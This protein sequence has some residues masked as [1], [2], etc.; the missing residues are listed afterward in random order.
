MLVST[1]KFLK[2][3]F[4][5]LYFF[6]KYLR[7][8]IF[9]ALLLNILVG[10][11]DGIGLTMF[12]PLLNLLEN[13]DKNPELGSDKIIDFIHKTGIDLNITNI[14]ILLMLVFLFK[15]TFKLL[16]SIFELNLHIKFIRS[17]RIELFKSFFNL[18][19]KYFVTQDVGHIQ[20]TFTGE[21]SKVSSACKSY[22]TTLNKSIIVATYIVLALFANYQFTFI[23]I[24]VGALSS[25]FYGNINKKT[26]NL[27]FVLVGRN[28]FFQKLIIEQIQNFKY[29][30]VSGRKNIF[31]KKVNTGIIDIEN[32]SKKIGLLKAISN[33]IREPILIFI[34]VI[35]ILIQVNFFSSSLNSILLSLLLFYRALQ[36]ALLLQTSWNSFLSNSGSL[37]N[38]MNFKKDLTKN[39]VSN[40]QLDIATFNDSINLEKVCFKY[41]NSIILSDINLSIKK[42]ETIAFVGES[43]SG[44]STLVNI[45]TG[46][47]PIDS[48]K[49]LFDGIPYKNLNINSFQKLIG[50][51]TQESIVFNDTIFNNVSFWDQRNKQTDQLFTNAIKNAAIS[52]FINQ[53][54]LKSDTLLGNNGVN[55]S[56]GQ[57][58]R[59]S[60]AREFY[61]DPLIFFMD[62]ATSSLD[63]ETEL[64][65][66]KNIS[67]LKGSK[68]IIIVAH[69]LSTIKNADRIVFMH[70]GRIKN[71]GDFDYLT[72]NEPT[73]EKMVLNQDLRHV[74]HSIISK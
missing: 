13:Q 3:Y 16:A 47:L 29:I 30:L 24:F 17:I 23:V 21:V 6:Y 1:K 25:V 63:S 15:A 22:L 14:L 58:Q 50:Y 71:I 18:N 44:K 65:V 37:E 31:N 55:L 69:R 72:K 64:I 43:G 11:L 56:G 54:E 9:I 51:I 20:N 45:L 42:N 48:G 52:D 7:F 12:L 73:F 62:E 32:N 19:Y 46:L 28:S 74:K 70:N 53:Q 27:S 60:I 2:K 5:S 49:I 66:Q 40:G 61:K 59:I 39:K 35:V 68:T 67:N 8:D 34:L 4:K 36:S 33:T 41:G 26:K 38:I 10:L 57:K